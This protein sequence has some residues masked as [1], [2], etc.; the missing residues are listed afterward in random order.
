[1]L[2]TERHADT[3][4]ELNVVRSLNYQ[5]NG[6]DLFAREGCS[7]ARV[8]AQRGFH[9][10]A[11][12]DTTLFLLEKNCRSAVTGL[13]TSLRPIDHITRIIRVDQSSKNTLAVFVRVVVCVP[14]GDGQTEM[15]TTRI[16]SKLSRAGL[17]QINSNFFFL[18][19]FYV[20]KRRYTLVS[21]DVRK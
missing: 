11:K 19:F 16:Y 13:F 6:F 21:R 18:F 8:E 4:A 7:Y 12:N 20:W 17:M 5:H 14:F 1:M 3:V 9:A 2:G 15:Y 10:R